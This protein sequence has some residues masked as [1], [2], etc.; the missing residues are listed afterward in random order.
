MP[1]T[2]AKIKTIRFR[3][4]R[5]EGYWTPTRLIASELIDSWGCPPD[6]GEVGESSYFGWKHSVALSTIIFKATKNGITVIF[7]PVP[8]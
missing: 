6:I 1:K 2:E 5:T 7:D 4:D 8:A 3:R